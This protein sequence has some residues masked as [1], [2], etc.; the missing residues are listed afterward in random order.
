MSSARSVAL[1]VSLAFV[2]GAIACS[3]FDEATDSAP[4]REDG[5]SATTDSGGGGGDAG[6]A[7]LDAGDAADAPY[8]QFCAGKNALFCADFDEGNEPWAFATVDAT[9]TTAKFTVTQAPDRRLAVGLTSAASNARRLLEQPIVVGTSF[10]VSFELSAVTGLDDQYVEIVDVQKTDDVRLTA[11]VDSRI[12]KVTMAVDTLSYFQVLNLGPAPAEPTRF[13]MSITP[14]T[15]SA[16]RN[17]EAVK[18]QT[19]P[20]NV[21]GLLSGATALGA[22]VYFANGTVTGSFALDDVLLEQ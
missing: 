15:F 17:D 13:R 1:I 7:D 20:Q 4:P 21:A 2:A 18:A 3:S 10:T 11:L 12:V 5:G 16:Q 9:G 6:G 8:V 19:L 14:T 22:G